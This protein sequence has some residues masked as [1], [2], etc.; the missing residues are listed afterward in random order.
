M[1]DDTQLTLCGPFTAKDSSGQIREVS[2]IRIV[3]ESYGVI[4]VHV[5]LRYPLEG[6]PLHEDLVLIRQISAHLRS[7]GYTGPD[8]IVGDAGLQDDQLIVLEAPEAFN[9]FA[10]KHG[11]KDLAAEFD[12]DLDE[13]VDD[14]SADNAPNTSDAAPS[15]APTEQL[16]ALLRKFQKK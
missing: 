8:L 9:A 1:S 6:D 16:T 3:D 4:D 13:S 2:A 12:D 14:T 15:P 11:W 5:A 10:E 7:L